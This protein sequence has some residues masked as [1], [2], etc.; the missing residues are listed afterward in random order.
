M[1]LRVKVRKTKMEI[2]IPTKAIA[3]VGRLSSGI[4]GSMA[5]KKIPKLKEIKYLGYRETF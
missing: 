2:T 1:A 5:L 4:S 3:V